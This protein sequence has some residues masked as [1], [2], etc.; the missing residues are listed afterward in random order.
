MSPDDCVRQ[1]EHFAD[2]AHLILEKF[3][4]RLDE[5][6]AEFFR[7]AADVVMEF[8]VRAMP[9]VSVAGFNDIGVERSLCKKARVSDVLRLAAESLDELSADDLPLFLRVDDALQVA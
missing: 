7:Q 1:A 8:D 3:A 4:Q 5:F 2:L 9:R 6:E